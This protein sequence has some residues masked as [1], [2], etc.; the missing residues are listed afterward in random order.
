[1]RLSEIVFKSLGIILFCLLVFY[2]D[3]IEFLDS[4]VTKISLLLIATFKSSFFVVQNFKKIRESSRY[5]IV[6]Y[7]FL[8][9]MGVNILLMII[10]FAVDF[11]SLNEICKDS[12]TGINPGLSLFHRGFEFLYYSILN[13]TNFGFGSL[14]PATTTAKIL[15]SMEVLLSFVAIIFVLSDFMSLRESIINRNNKNAK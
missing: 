9:F 2:I 15:T 11:L 13:M 5:N 6:Y 8:L 10:S 7:Q 3:S 12:F 4:S 1:M 14:I